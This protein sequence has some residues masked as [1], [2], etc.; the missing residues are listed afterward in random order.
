MRLDRCVTSPR[1]RDTHGIIPTLASGPASRA[2][3]TTFGRGRS[4]LTE[5]DVLRSQ[6][7]ENNG[8]AAQ[9]KLYPVRHDEPSCIEG[10]S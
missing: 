1:V 9:L 5:A 2:D 7:Y 10:N 6:K 8:A 3:V 4:K